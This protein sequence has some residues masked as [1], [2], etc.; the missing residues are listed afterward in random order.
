MTIIENSQS[1]IHL[2]QKGTSWAYWD[3]L[4]PSLDGFHRIVGFFVIHQLFSWPLIPLVSFCQLFKLPLVVQCCNVICEWPLIMT[5]YWSP[6]T[7]GSI[8][9][10]TADV[11]TADDVPWHILHRVLR[12]D[13]TFHPSALTFDDSRWYLFLTNTWSSFK[14]SSWCCCYSEIQKLVQLAAEFSVCYHNRLRVGTGPTSVSVRVTE[15][16]CSLQSNHPCIISRLWM[17]SG[18]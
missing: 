8:P 18:Y 13:F 15:Y 10:H 16:L 7:S 5:V 9:T 12:R 14:S 4:R 2:L 17:V 11:L 6:V 1:T 3:P